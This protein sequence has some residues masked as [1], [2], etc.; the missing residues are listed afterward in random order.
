MD[1]NPRRVLIIGVLLAFLANTFGPLPSAQ[2]QVSPAI[3]GDFRLPAPGA[4]V[5]LSPAFEP[6]LIKGLTV[7]KDNPFLFDFIVDT[8]HSG[9]SGD[10]LKKEGD[11][12]IK[13]FFACLTIPE[14][15][16]WVNLSPY[17]KDRMAPKA[18]GQTALG[19]DLLAQ[20]YMLKQ[21]TAS[22]IYPER[23]LGKE[24]WNRVYTKAQ[25][26]YGNAQIPVNTFNKVWIMAD[27]ATVY[28]H[29]QTAF[30]LDGHL[31]VM[32]EEDYL[33]LTKHSNVA[34]SSHTNNLGSQIVREIVLPEIE[35]EVNTGKNFSALRQIFNSLVLASWYKKNLKEALLNQ[36]YSDKSTVKGVNLSDPSVKERIYQQYLKAYKKGVFN[37]IKEDAADGQ[38]IPR[39]YFSG[40]F[41]VNPDMLTVIKSK[42]PG[43]LRRASR[44]VS[45]LMNVAVLT[46]AL[47]LNQPNSVLANSTTPS[48]AAM[49]GDPSNM[50]RI[51]G[52]VVGLSIY[53]NQV[54]NQ[55]DAL[56]EDFQLGHVEDD[57]KEQ[58]ESWKMIRL[59]SFTKVVGKYGSQD[60]FIVHILAE[61]LNPYVTEIPQ[62]TAMNGVKVWQDKKDM[63]TWYLGWASRSGKFDE[64]IVMEARKHLEELKQKAIWK[65]SA[66]IFKNKQ[67]QKLKKNE[68]Y[69]QN[70]IETARMVL[71]KLLQAIDDNRSLRNAKDKIQQAIE[72]A[73]D[74]QIQSLQ[75]GSG[76][77]LIGPLEKALDLIKNGSTDPESIVS[78]IKDSAMMETHQAA[79][80]V[81]TRGGIDLNTANMGMTVTRNS[82][83]GVKVNFDPDMIARIR[84]Q[85]IQSAVPIIIDV[86]M[87]SIADIRPLLGFN[88]S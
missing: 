73:F 36:V 13:Y 56:L 5:N 65:Q 12:L 84:Q 83:G 49:A 55:A 43:T 62:G 40:G 47:V 8:G 86:H 57:R 53:P 58:F 60:Y 37:Y 25:K 54:K 77:S 82:Q 74:T 9:I 70:I 28:E 2:A 52:A 27:K 14:K 61:A 21:L 71:S 10:A 17:E 24:F 38:A 26:L 44:F 39:K 85:G 88:L 34:G 30:V 64:K 3:G 66:N 32:L 6:A 78:A 22:L 67:I 80:T 15:D 72:L 76:L 7:H 18:L 63:K 69:S 11:R 75:P 42:T 81:W 4:M 1:L 31:K 87:I 51:Y 46:A 35:K 19:R 45:G 23:N 68:H 16:L 41:D 29:N 33:A 59:S 48:D 20:D 79:N 50:L